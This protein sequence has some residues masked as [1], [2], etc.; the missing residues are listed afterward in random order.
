MPTVAGFTVV[1]DSSF[2]LPGEPLNDR[3]FGSAG[4][5]AISD[6]IAAASSRRSRTPPPACSARG[7]RSPRVALASWVR[8]GGLRPD[9]GH[10][11]GGTS[12]DTEATRALIQRFVD[13][14]A[15]N[16]AATIAD[17]LTEDAVWNAPVSA[18]IGPFTGRDEVVKALTGGAAGTVLDVSTIKREVRTIIVD[19]ARAVVQ[20]RLTATARNGNPYANEYCWVYTCRDNKVQI[21]EEY[22]DT[23]YAGRVFGWVKD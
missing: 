4:R 8:M 12:M 23:L 14:R 10:D 9:R 17:L 7:C 1:S 13:A 3:H 18:K 16:D 15:N 11:A 20:Q 2:T 21:L 22:A 5:P 6:P 19:G